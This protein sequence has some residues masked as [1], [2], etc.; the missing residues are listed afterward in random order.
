[1]KQVWFF[2]VELCGGVHIRHHFKE[3]SLY[4]DNL[5]LT[6]SSHTKNSRQISTPP[7][8]TPIKKKSST[9]NR[10]KILIILFYILD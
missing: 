1:M 3:S 5:C 10:P 8:P 2:L 6:T 7:P 4:F 9:F